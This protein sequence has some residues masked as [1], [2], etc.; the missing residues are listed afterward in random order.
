VPIVSGY[1]AP[2]TELTIWQIEP[3]V[4]SGIP[5]AVSVVCSTDTMT[6]LSGAPAAPGVRT[7]AQPMETGGPGI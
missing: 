7:T 4:A 6:P 2:L 3:D 1:G 5:D